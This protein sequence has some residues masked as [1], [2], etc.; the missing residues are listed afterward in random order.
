MPPLSDE[1][2]YRILKLLEQNPEMNQRQ[3]AHALDISLGKVNYCLQ[4]LIEKGMI[5]AA[6]FRNSKNKRA[7]AYLL[8]L[9]GIEE[10]ARVTLRFLERKQREYD[11][12]EQEI[13]SL[14][15]EVRQITAHTTPRNS[16]P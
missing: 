6:N 5:K 16:N 3:I 14:R 2:R 12:L 9:K 15:A 8:T 7:Y 11:A 10:K 1:N 4:A 13:A